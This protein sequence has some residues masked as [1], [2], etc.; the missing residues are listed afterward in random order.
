MFYKEQKQK[1]INLSVQRNKIVKN[2]TSNE[3]SL[4]MER[5]GFFETN[6]SIAISY[7]GGS[8]SSALLLKLSEWSKKIMQSSTL[9][10]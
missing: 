10:L 8:D 4:L 7:S 2:I 1:K 5:I 9:L 3:F 6:P